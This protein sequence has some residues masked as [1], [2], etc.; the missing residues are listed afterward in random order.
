MHLDR[1]NR[2]E[3]SALSEL[4]RQEANIDNLIKTSF[5]ALKKEIADEFQNQLSEAKQNQEEL[6]RSIQTLKDAVAKKSKLSELDERIQ[7]VSSALDS[8]SA[9]LQSVESNQKLILL[10]L[11][12]NHAD[13]VLSQEDNDSRS[14][15]KG[16][17]SR[18]DALSTRKN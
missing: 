2:Q 8:L 16:F 13:Q 3:L 4:S 1:L 15:V 10:D 17:A 7:V 11:V 6:A 9:K 5:A 18:E 14:N 12:M